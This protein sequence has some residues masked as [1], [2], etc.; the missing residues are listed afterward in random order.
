[1]RSASDGRWPSRRGSDVSEA[2]DL[3][4]EAQEAKRGIDTMCADHW[5]WQ[6]DN[7]NG[8]RG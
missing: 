1:M 6:S 3:I 4:H 2:I 5:R 7:P 8:Y